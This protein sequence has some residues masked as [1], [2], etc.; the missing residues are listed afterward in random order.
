MV[1]FGIV[2]DDGCGAVPWYFLPATTGVIGPTG[3]TIGGSASVDCPVALG[4]EPMTVTRQFT[5]A[6][7]KSSGAVN[8]P[9]GCLVSDCGLTVTLKVTE[10]PG[11]V[12][13][14]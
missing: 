9:F 12:E 11:V 6:P 7:A 14:A 4:L 10:A 13:T 8:E 2:T 3:A 1:M 5:R